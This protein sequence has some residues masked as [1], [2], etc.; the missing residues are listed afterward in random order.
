MD[1]LM[2][3][4]SA[5]VEIGGRN[6]MMREMVIQSIRTDPDFNNGDYTRPLRGMLGAEF[7]LFM[8]TSSP[9]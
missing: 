8:M 6:R 7:A 5:P 9:L 2:P 1:A 4:A 3:L